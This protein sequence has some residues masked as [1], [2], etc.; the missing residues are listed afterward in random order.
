MHLGSTTQSTR[1]GRKVTAARCYPTAACF[2]ISRAGGRHRW[3]GPAWD[4]W[5]E[6][7]SLFLATAVICRATLPMV[8]L[9]ARGGERSKRR[10]PSPSA[11]FLTA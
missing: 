5:P 8:R 9:G 11:T 3:Q 2:R 7:Q 4:I 6:P 1:T 10:S